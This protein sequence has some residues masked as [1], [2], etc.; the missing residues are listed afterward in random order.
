MKCPSVFWSSGYTYK[1][2]PLEAYSE[3]PG[4]NTDFGI[5]L[6][7]YSVTSQLQEL[8]QILF[9][10][11]ILLIGK[12]KT[13]EQG[14]GVMMTLWTVAHQAPLSMG[15]SRQEY[16]SGLSF[17]SPGDLRQVFMTILIYPFLVFMSIQVP[18][19]FLLL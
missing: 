4:K 18:P 10:N 19:S 1:L 8:G 15:F 12:I 3:Y 13:Q 9:L 5:I 7:S 2:K 17:P 14:N 6:V 11:L 16:W